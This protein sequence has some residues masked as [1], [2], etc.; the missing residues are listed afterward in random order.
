MRSTVARYPDFTVI[1]KYSTTA[2]R[3]FINQHPFHVL[4][5]VH[6]IMLLLRSAL[7]S[8]NRFEVI[9]QINYMKILKRNQLMFRFA[10]FYAIIIAIIKNIIFV[11]ATN[12][13]YCMITK[14]RLCKYKL[15]TASFI[16]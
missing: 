8:G 15:S 4:F 3:K 6:I 7:I 5:F 11:Q 13:N 2:R 16:K 10:T 12:I 14:C 9:L 1:R